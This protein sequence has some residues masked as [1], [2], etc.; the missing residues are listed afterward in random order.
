[1]PRLDRPT[2]VLLATLLAAPLSGQEPAQSPAAVA[3]FRAGQ[4]AFQREE[5]DAAIA[6][7]KAAIAA[8]P[9][10]A[11]AHCA[12]GQVYMT[13][14]RY[15]DAIDALVRCKSLGERQAGAAAA[16][17]VAQ[18]RDADRE[19]QSL[20]QAIGDIQSG[21]TKAGEFEVTQMESR[22]RQLEE[23]RNRSATQATTGVPPALSFA[24]GTAYLRVGALE[25]AERELGAALR[26]KPDLA[27]AHNN[28]AA[29]YAGLGRWDEAADHVKRAEASGFAVSPALKA[30]IAARRAPTPPVAT[31]GGTAGASAETPPP[32]PVAELAI[33]HVPVACVSSASFPRLQAHVTPEGSASAKVFFRTDR[34]SGWYSVRLR[35]D[36]ERYA[37]ILPRPRSA[38]SFRY[39]IEATGDDTRTTRTPEYLTAVVDQPEECA[40]KK[41]DAVASATGI[42]VEAPPAA[43]PNAKPRPVPAG[44]STRG[45]VGDVGQFEMGPV[46]AIGAGAALAGAAVAGA[47]AAGKKEPATP[48]TTTIPVR[49]DLGG[50]IQL[51]SSNPPPGGTISLTGTVVSMAFRAVSPY[52]VPA[53]PVRVVFSRSSSFFNECAT[54]TGEHPDL[55]ANEPLTLTV[56][57]R[58]AAEAQCGDQFSVRLLRVFFQQAGG[59][60]VLQTGNGFIPDLIVNYDV[61]P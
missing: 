61:V 52:A 14:R 5:F 53:G 31:A 21:H 18:E 40:G 12:L 51:L 59:P 20:R 41:T 27:E 54:L 8:D 38:R 28:L 45:T 30:D 56:S 55:R 42:V 33:E 10:L 36:D 32:A 37:A 11:A 7:F 57:G 39:Y 24:L 58:I 35:S 60:Q 3:A 29:V 19:I 15:P 50:D 16:A 1:M 22:L 44:F 13:L 6:D 46:M 48:T 43:R 26:Q 17:R 2:A 47:M 34:D 4:E 49:P 25:A 9:R 23:A